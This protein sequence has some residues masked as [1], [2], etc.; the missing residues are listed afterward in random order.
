MIIK[1]LKCRIIKKETALN[2][3]RYIITKC[4]EDAEFIS[5]V[6][7]Q[8]ILYLIQLHW[9]KK[10]KKELFKEQFYSYP[11]GPAI[12]DIYWTYCGYGK[13]ILATYTDLNIDKEIIKEI[14]PII[15]E[16][17]KNKIWEDKRFLVWKDI[18]QHIPID[19]FKIKEIEL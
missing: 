1:K 4:V 2:I 14:D 3:A 9:I 6:Q 17:R 18:E 13:V 7:L 8:R 5:N 11:C 19:I 12:P 10:F 15:E 16:E